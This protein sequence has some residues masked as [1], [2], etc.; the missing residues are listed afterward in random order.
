MCQP[1]SFV[2]MMEYSPSRDFGGR[3]EFLRCNVNDVRSGLDLRKVQMGVISSPARNLSNVSG[4][5]VDAPDPQPAKYDL[6]HWRSLHV[7]KLSFRV[8]FHSAKLA[9]E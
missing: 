1:E 3:I 6:L 4:Q 2:E 8:R 7:T 9:E 5:S